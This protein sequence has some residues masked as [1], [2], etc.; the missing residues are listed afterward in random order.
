MYICICNAVTDS[1][2]R[3]AVEDGARTLRELSFKT[4]CSTQCGR[5]VVRAREV[6]NEALADIGEGPAPADLLVVNA[7]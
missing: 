3:D 5:C 4:R 2:I 7:R 1:A 6:M